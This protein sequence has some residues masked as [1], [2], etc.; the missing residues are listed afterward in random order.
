[1]KYKR[2]YPYLPTTEELVQAHKIRKTYAIKG[3]TIVNAGTWFGS[4]E[5]GVRQAK[6]LL[7]EIKTY[8]NLLPQET[9]LEQALDVIIEDINYHYRHE[10]EYT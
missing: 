5:I 3:N 6:N 2:L 7:Q 10:K 4:Q 8:R 1:M 9:I